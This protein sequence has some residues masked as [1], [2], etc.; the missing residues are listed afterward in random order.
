MPRKIVGID[1]SVCD[2]KKCKDGICQAALACEK[3]LLTQ[4]APYEM[5]DVKASM[6]M[7]CALCVEACPQGA[8]RVM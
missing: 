4:E 7:S 6:C 8:V 3:K 1:Y 2:P 5:P